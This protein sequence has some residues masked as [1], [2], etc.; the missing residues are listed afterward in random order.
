[1]PDV[2]MQ[3]RSKKI[4]KAI[5][6]IPRVSAPKYLDK[7]ILKTKDINLVIIELN[8]IMEKALYIFFTIYYIYAHLKI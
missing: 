8:V 6:Y 4:E 7:Y 1:M 5:W 3:D 2:D